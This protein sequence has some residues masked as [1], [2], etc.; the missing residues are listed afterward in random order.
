MDTQRLILLFIFGFSVLMLWE[1]WDRE[2]RPKP[3]AVQAAQPA[4][5]TPAKAPSVA[6]PPG[7]VAPSAPAEAAGEVI[8]ITTDLIIAEIDTR[9]GTL[10]RLELLRHK[11]SN[12]PD[13]NFVLIGPAHQYEAQTGLAGEGGPNHR[14]LWRAEAGPRT[15]APGAESVALRLTAQGR[16]GVEVEK[17][18]TF[19]RNSYVIDVSFQV[20]N[21]GSAPLATYA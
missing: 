2:H 9:G 18:Y 12:D 14:S 4:V 8:R 13:K 11:D 7:Q 15:L 19:K 6:P 21:G 17:T 5:P 10:K 3:P 1:A 20:R 16:D